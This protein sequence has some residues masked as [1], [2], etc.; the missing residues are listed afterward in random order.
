MNAFGF[1]GLTV[2]S[3]SLGGNRPTAPARQSTL[4]PCGRLDSR[5]LRHETQWEGTLR[6]RRAIT[7]V[8]LCAVVAGALSVVAIPAGAQDGVAMKA[9]KDQIRA[10]RLPLDVPANGLGSR[11]ATT[12]FRTL[13]TLSGG[14]VTS[15]K[16][17]F[18]NDG[19]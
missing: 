10:A 4:S 9:A 13:P 15:A 2:L 3:F 19:A 7:L 1:T 18:S 11:A 16:A 12:T 17:A 5:V 8:G 6:I 14:F